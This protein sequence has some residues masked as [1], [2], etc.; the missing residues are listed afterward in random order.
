MGMHKLDV[1]EWLVSAVMPMH[2]G[3]RTVV[4]T[5]YGSSDNFDVTAG[6][7]QGSALSLLLFVTVMET[8]S[9]Q[10][11]DVLPWELLYVNDLV[12]IAESREELIKKLNRRKH[13][14]MKVN[15]NKSKVMISGKT[16]S[17]YTILEDGHVVFVVEVLA[18]TQYSVLTVRNGCTGSVVE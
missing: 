18:E 1:D 3:A 2:M 15:I 4:R 11:T 9:R 7:H 5:V 17:E 8:I 6:I 12:V 16:A 13:E 14:G 10:F